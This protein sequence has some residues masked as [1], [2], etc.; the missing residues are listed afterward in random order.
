MAPSTTGSVHARQRATARGAERE[1]GTK[2]ELFNKRLLATAA[3]FETDVDHA[4][5]N[6]NVKA[7]TP[8][9]ARAFLG[10]YR[11]R[12]FEAGLAGNITTLERVT[13]ELFSRH[14]GA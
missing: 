6:D 7:T 14:G 8:D 2:W 3:V 12:G 1:V 13:A 9:P 5:T 10:K 11:V 4:R